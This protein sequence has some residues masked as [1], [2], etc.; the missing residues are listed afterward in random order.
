MLFFMVVFVSGQNESKRYAIITKPDGE[1]VR[2][3]VEPG[4]NM[5]MMAR[6]GQKLEVIGEPGVLWLKVKTNS[7]E[8]YIQKYSCRI[9]EEGGFKSS[10][11]GW[12]VLLII[13]LGAV[14]GGVYF[15][16][17]KKGLVSKKEPN[18]S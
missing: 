4:T 5:I 9:I 7:G 1:I 8:G 11:I 10:S 15:F 17:Y 12:A 3:S 2:A 6:K 14:G 13:L 18:I 16:Y